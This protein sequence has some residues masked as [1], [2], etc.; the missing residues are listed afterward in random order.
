MLVVL[1]LY[2]IDIRIYTAKIVAKLTG[3]SFDERALVTNGGTI[4]NVEWENSGFVAIAVLSFL[5]FVTGDFVEYAL[6]TLIYFALNIFLLLIVVYAPE[7]YVAF[8]FCSAFSIVIAYVLGYY[9]VSRVKY[10]KGGEK[11][12]PPP[13]AEIAKTT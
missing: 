8:W 2:A 5:F 4:L 12:M 13:P 9:L 7:A 6:S 3:A 10:G 1:A 11:P